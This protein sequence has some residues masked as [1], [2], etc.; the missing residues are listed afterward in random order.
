VGLI[1]NWA[2]DYHRRTGRWPV[3]CPEVVPGTGGLTWRA[4]D[5]HLRGGY[6]GLPGGDSLARLLA[7]RLG[8]RN[9]ASIPRLS[10]RLILRWVDAHHAATG[11][12]P[13]PASGPVAG[14]PG[15]NWRAV[16]DALKCGYRGLPGGDS[17]AKVLARNRAGRDGKA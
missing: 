13:D 11:S 15:E 9:R 8:V 5:G 16:N 3:H 17:L 6:R 10:V 7:R 1:L 2:R 12:W 14:A 4:I